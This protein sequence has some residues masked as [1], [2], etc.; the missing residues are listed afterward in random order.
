MLAL[1]SE[2]LLLRVVSWPPVEKRGIVSLL[3]TKT[4]ERAEAKWGRMVCLVNAQTPP[5]L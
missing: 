2:Y 3:G 5:A 1:P 4:A